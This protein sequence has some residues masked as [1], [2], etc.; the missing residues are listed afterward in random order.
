MKNNLI[1][2]NIFLTNMTEIKDISK[3]FS[4]IPTEMNMRNFLKNMFRF[5]EWG[6]VERT[7]GNIKYLETLF[8]YVFHPSELS[9]RRKVNFDKVVK[10]FNLKDEDISQRQKVFQIYCLIFILLTLGIWAYLAYTLFQGKYLVCLTIFCISL[11]PLSLAFRF[12]FYY[13]VL[14]MR[15]FDYSIKDWVKDTK[16]S[17]KL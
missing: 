2:K 3:Y 7:K 16:Q 6:D 1:I 10:R 11:I 15:K 14:K 9:K 12:N 5:K 4:I 8:Y 17:P 13:R